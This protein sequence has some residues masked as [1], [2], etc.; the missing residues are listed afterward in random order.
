MNNHVVGQ[1]THV[2]Q[3]S[4]KCPNVKHS[5]DSGATMPDDMKE[6]QISGAGNEA[7]PGVQ[8]G[9]ETREPMLPKRRGWLA[10]EG[11]IVDLV[12]KPVKELVKSVLPP[13][14]QEILGIREPP[15]QKEK[16]PIIIVVNP[17]TT[18]ETTHNRAA[19][20]VSQPV[21]P[22]IEDRPSVTVKHLL[23][24]SAGAS[25]RIPAR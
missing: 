21:T 22:R 6:Q 20:A 23:D 19:R 2:F 7:S 3:M 9:R 4:N 18:P 13:E 25:V 17:G 5:G 24:A 11:L 14:V 12:A 8:I 1:V 15:K 10:E 16:P